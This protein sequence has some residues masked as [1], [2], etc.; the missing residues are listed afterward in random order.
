MADHQQQFGSEC[1][2]C[3]DGVDRLNN[4]DHANF[5]PLDGKHATTDCITCH[6]DNV[7]RGTPSECD[8]CHKE[9]D[10]HVGVFGFKCFYCHTADAWSP[11][12]LRQHNFPLNHGVEDQNLQLQ[13]DACH[14]SNYNE[15]MCYNCH[16]HQ[17]D[18]IAQSHASLKI[19]DQDLSAC[20]KCHPAGTIETNQPSP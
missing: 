2:G 17:P 10:I 20:V 8:Q 19:A 5:F 7:Y 3:H 6:A 1:M 15:Y 13:C 11:A 14:G 12:S 16:D 4:F 9:P 18:A